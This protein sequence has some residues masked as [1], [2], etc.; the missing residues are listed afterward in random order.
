VKFQTRFVIPNKSASKIGI[1]LAATYL[2]DIVTSKD[3]MENIDYWYF[4]TIYCKNFPKPFLMEINEQQFLEDR[5]VLR[6]WINYCSDEPYL[7]KAA[8]E[9]RHP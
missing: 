7:C 9:L 3:S 6:G 5:I 8:I 1:D 2:T 4:I